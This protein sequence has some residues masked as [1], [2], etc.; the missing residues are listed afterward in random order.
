MLSNSNIL[1]IK[2][3]LNKTFE[4]LNL[5]E[6]YLKIPIFLWDISPL[7]F[8][9]ILIGVGSSKCWVLSL[10]NCAIRTFLRFINFPLLWSSTD[11]LLLSMQYSFTASSAPRV[12]LF[13]RKWRETE[14]K[15]EI[16]L[17]CLQ[18]PLVFEFYFLKYSQ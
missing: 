5:V 3:Y 16:Y 1:A 10:L 12:R 8:N 2:I 17:W 14:T 7:Y 13:L 6:T 15:F 4:E 9:G 18:L 11:S